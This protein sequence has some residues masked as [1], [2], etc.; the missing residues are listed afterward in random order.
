[1]SQL[2]TINAQAQRAAEEISKNFGY[3]LIAKPID[4]VT[5][6]IWRCKD[7]NSFEYA[8][9]LVIT[10][11]G[12]CSFGDM[13][14]LMFTVGANYGLKFLSGPD[15]S[16]YIYSKLD[17]K[18]KDEQVDM[19]S[20]LHDF[21]IQLAKHLNANWSFN[22]T[23]QVP[24]GPVAIAL[25]KL[26]KSDSENSLVNISAMIAAL[27]Q[28]DT[29]DWP[30]FWSGVDREMYPD[31]MANAIDLFMS[32]I[33]GLTEKDHVRYFINESDFKNLFDDYEIPKTPGL[34]ILT[35]LHVLNIG[36]KRIMQ[37]QSESQGAVERETPITAKAIGKKDAV[38]EHAVV[39]R[40]DEETPDTPALR[41][42]P[43]C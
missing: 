15:V 20:F 43:S 37:I 2:Q 9:D 4:G 35:R 33:Q 40:P 27:H 28:A 32:D 23:L 22:G 34:G 24:E 5:A 36:A 29:S 13:D 3:Q 17:S 41:E 26:A 10:R 12:I 25:S 16:Y 42:R 38:V 8:H 6:E 7:P 11:M 30:M 18:F 31:Y 39:P 1:M 19:P 21:S 14:P